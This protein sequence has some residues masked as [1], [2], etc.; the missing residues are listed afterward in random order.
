MNNLLKRSLTGLV[1]VVIILGSLLLGKFFYILTFGAILTGALSEFYSFF[2]NGNYQPNRT[3]GYVLGLSVFIVSFVTAAEYIPSEWSICIFPLLLLVFIIEL[4]RKKPSPVENI[5][6]TILAIL[7]IS[8]PFGLISFLVFPVSEDSRPFSPDLFI[9]VL[10]IIWL[11][12]SFAYLFGI[13]MGRHRLFERISPK[14]SWE[15]AIGGA[16]FTIAASC[17]GPFFIPEIS[18]A[19]WIILS[20]LIV[21]SATFGDLTES[22]IKRTVGIKDSSNLIPGHGGILDRFDSLLFVIPVVVLY[23]KLFIE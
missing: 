21:V 8:V 4:Y 9:A 15:G 20:I 11:Y 12:D 18:I 2:K 19:N 14:K 23:L 22:L 5:A 16:V 3:I 7:Y 10:V 6:I 17:T 1:F 13:S